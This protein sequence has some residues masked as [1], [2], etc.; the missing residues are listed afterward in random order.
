MTGCAPSSQRR[1]R[2]TLHGEIVAVALFAQLYHNQLEGEMERLK[3]FMER[4]DMPLP[5]MTWAWR[6]MRKTLDSGRIS[7]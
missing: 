7:H 4:M 5:W 2:R 1:Q 3:R 6:A